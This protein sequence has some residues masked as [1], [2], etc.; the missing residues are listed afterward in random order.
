MKRFFPGVLVLLTPVFACAEPG[1]STRHVPFLWGF[2]AVLATLV[3]VLPFV[4]ARGGLFF[5][6]AAKKW[7]WSIALFVLF[8]VFAAPIIVVFGSIVITGRTM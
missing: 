6:T 2:A 7:A 1:V 4:V 3:A 5:Q 8:M